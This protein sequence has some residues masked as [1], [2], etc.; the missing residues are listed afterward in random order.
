M[1]G[2]FD[3]GSGGLTVLTKIR[4]RLPSSDVLYF[5]DI[6]HAPY[7]LRS[8]EDLSLLTVKAV[9]LLVKN[10]A[11]SI[12]SACNSVSASLALSLFDTLSVPAER[13]VEMVGPAVSSFRD[14]D[15]R[16]LLTATPAT[17]DSGI[18]QSAFRMLGKEITTVAIPELAG[19]I[20]SGVGREEIKS[21][22]QKAFADISLNNFDVLVLACTHYPLVSDVFEEVLGRGI[23]LFDPADAVAQRIE[24]RW[25][26]REVGH[27]K[28]RFLISKD[29][30][31]FRRL[32]ADR[33]PDGAYSIEVL[34]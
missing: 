2:L 7:G 14:S 15:A 30:E 16:I 19:A 17:I 9:E 32:V 8:R 18:Y 24:E 6:K 27:G 3:S 26:P 5:G 4:E 13:L 10:G 21:I 20:E 23:R 28:L 25:W 12:V 33:F 29:S 11:T 34:E 22:I 31:P 1:I